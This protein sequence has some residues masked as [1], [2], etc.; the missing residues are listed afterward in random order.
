M[1]A[2][3]YR[4]F[5]ADRHLPSTTA[6]PREDAPSTSKAQAHI[7]LPETCTMSDSYI[8]VDLPF[9]SDPALLEVSLSF[10][11]LSLSFNSL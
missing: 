1:V 8:E 10:V 7:Q 11:A 6:V 4:G 2:S 3:V 5:W 9:E